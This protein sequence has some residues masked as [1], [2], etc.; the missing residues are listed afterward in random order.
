MSVGRRCALGC[1]TWPDILLFQ[2]CY[3]CGEETRRVRGDS[4]DP[5][6]DEE[7]MKIASYHEFEKFYERRC[8]RLGIPVEGPIPEPQKQLALASG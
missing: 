1:M 2:R 4:V 6:S 7:A 8:R 5:I 3:I